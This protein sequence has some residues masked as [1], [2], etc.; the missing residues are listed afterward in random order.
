MFPT[1]AGRLAVGSRL[2][3][4]A[5]CWSGSGSMGIGATWI[6]CGTGNGATSKVVQSPCGGLATEKG[7]ARMRSNASG[8]VTAT[9]KGSYRGKNC[10]PA[11]W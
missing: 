5:L 4:N 1:A 2:L 10:K 8:L 7:E 6:S 9:K 3:G 11:G